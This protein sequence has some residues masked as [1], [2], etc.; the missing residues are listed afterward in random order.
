[1]AIPTLAE[2]VKANVTGSEPRPCYWRTSGNGHEDCEVTEYR[3]AM[4]LT[5]GSDKA[6]RITFTEHSVE[7][8][9]M[10]A[11]AGPSCG[12]KRRGLNWVSAG[13]FVHEVTCGRC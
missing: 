1:M 10:F 3:A 4:I 9:K 7:P 6:H 5:H 2:K 8:G 11:P 12:S 13:R